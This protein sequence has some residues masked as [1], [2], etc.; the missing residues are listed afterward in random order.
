MCY[1]AL[2]CNPESICRG[3][4]RHPRLSPR[5][6]AVTQARRTVAAAGVNI[7]M[8]TTSE[9]RITTIIERDQVQN[10]VEALHDAFE[11]EK[12]E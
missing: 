5:Q 3:H 12:T 10:A 8:I 9:I 1:G 11:L 2:F 7:D 6:L 4:W